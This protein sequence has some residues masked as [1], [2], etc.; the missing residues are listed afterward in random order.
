VLGG[1]ERLDRVEALLLL[2]H[3]GAY[4]AALLLVL[5]PLR[6]AAFL[7]LQQGLFGLYLGCCF[8]PTIRAC[9]YSKKARSPTTSAARC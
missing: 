3:A 5:S 4:V 9:P 6:A 7:L 2:V 1:R 8:A